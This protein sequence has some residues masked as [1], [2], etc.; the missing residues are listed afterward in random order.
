MLHL[1]VHAIFF[2]KSCIGEYLFILCLDNIFL[3]KF[4]YLA[5]FF[6]FAAFVVASNLRL[7]GLT[8]YATYATTYSAQKLHPFYYT[9]NFYNQNQI[10]AFEFQ[11]QQDCSSHGEKYFWIDNPSGVNDINCYCSSG[12]DLMVINYS[13]S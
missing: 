1:R 12:K 13:N 5:L 10:G 7:F 3:M 4:Q 6:I 2:Q 9:G 11:C 8:G